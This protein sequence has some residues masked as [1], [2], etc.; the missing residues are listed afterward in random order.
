MTLI[1]SDKPKTV[2]DV[3]AVMIK[4]WP[5]LFDTRMDCLDRVFT[6]EIGWKDGYPSNPDI[7]TKSTD[8]YNTTVDDIIEKELK[9][10][11]ER[12]SDLGDKAVHDRSVEATLRIKKDNCY[13]EFKIRNADLIA[14]TKITTDKSFTSYPSFST[15]HLNRRI[16]FDKLNHDWQLAFIE[17][18]NEILVF[19]KCHLDFLIAS[20]V[21]YTD[22]YKK[23]IKELVI[24]AARSAKEGLFRFDPEFR[25][26]QELSKRNQI[27]QNLFIEAE[28]YGYTL[29]PIV[30]NK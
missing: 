30:D 29:S 22:D 20:Y 11:S 17:Y 21:K 10:I 28:K 15:H 24:E 26:K 14:K 12:Y 3:L 16:P 8:Y 19:E 7:Y 4:N 18:C 13:N 1:L 23:Q 9:D 6:F 5:T 27:V 25:E 2:N